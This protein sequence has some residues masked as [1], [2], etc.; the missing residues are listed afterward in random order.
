MTKKKSKSTNMVASNAVGL[1]DTLTQKIESPVV[2]QPV[3][4]ETALKFV[5]SVKFEQLDVHY[6]W[7][8][9]LDYT[10]EDGVLKIVQ[11]KDGRWS[12]AGD[13]AED[14][15]T[16]MGAVS[17][18]KTLLNTALVTGARLQRFNMYVPGVN[19]LMTEKED[20]LLSNVALVRTLSDLKEI[21][22]VIKSRPFKNRRGLY[23]TVMLYPKTT[24]TVPD[25]PTLTGYEDLVIQ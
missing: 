11:K 7:T 14:G 24:V 17:F 16:K 22:I 12:V 5:N 1:T 21:S 20:V 4:K 19:E 2:A 23:P 10:V 3:A 6:N 9:R 8:G 18:V 13:V 15:T 25:E